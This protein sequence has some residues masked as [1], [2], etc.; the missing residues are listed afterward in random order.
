MI[1]L[2]KIENNKSDLEKKY[3]LITYIIEED[4]EKKKYNKWDSGVIA[5][6]VISERFSNKYIYKDFADYEN[7]FIIPAEVFNINN[8][9]L[10]IYD[11]DTKLFKNLNDDEIENEIENFF[12]EPENIF[13]RKNCCLS[14]GD[15][16][17]YKRKMIEIIK[18]EL[19]NFCKE[20]RLHW[21][22][23]FEKNY[24]AVVLK[25]GTLFLYYKEKKIEFKEEFDPN[26]LINLIYKVVQIRLSNKN[27]SVQ[28]S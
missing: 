18:K 14:I 28:E 2:K 4:Q 11:A 6:Y 5:K 15:W 8:G 7:S 21:S 9:N 12:N 3:E 1:V 16:G 19:N 22:N 25:N 17:N 20:N 27:A 26:F 24:I 10:K 23:S 13:I